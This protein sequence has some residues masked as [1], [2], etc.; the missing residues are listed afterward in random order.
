VSVPPTYHAAGRTALTKTDDSAKGEW[1]MLTRTVAL[2][3]GLTAMLTAGAATAQEM[4]PFGGDEDTGYA[5]ELW[6]AMEARGLVGENMIQAF[7]YEG[8]D[9]HGM[10]L[11]TF[12][13]RATV[14]GHTGTLVVKRNYGPAG[15]EAEQVLAEPGKH[16]GAITV[17][18]RRE[19]GYD[20]DNQDWFWA[21]YLPDGSLDRN[22]K[23]IALAG[24][25]AKGMDA[26]CIA[27]HAGAGG[28]DYI[29][30][31]DAIRPE[32]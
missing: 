18:F 1:K 11:E 25:V 23:G 3:L 15:V 14:D 5:A 24:R 31:T 22:P 8:T 27:C 16:L 6:A 20:P 9:P 32:M 7:P 13:T 29:F 26:G 28:D 10:M 17:M 12:Y 2:S 30:T 4:M 19:K 21:K